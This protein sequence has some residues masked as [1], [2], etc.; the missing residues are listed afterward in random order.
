[1]RFTQSLIRFD[2]ILLLTAF[3]LV[4]VGLVVMYGI[5]ISRPES[6]LFLFQKQIAGA[7]IGLAVIIGLGF[8]DYR[9]LRGLALP[10]YAAGAALLVGVLLF[11]H[12]VRGTKGWYVV[13]GLSFQPVEMAKLCL[14]LF[15]ASYLARYTHQR[16]RWHAVAGSFLGTAG[17]AALVFLQPDFGSAMVMFAIWGIL[18]LCVGLT[19]KNVLVLSLVALVMAGMAWFLLL[20][21]YQHARF[22]AFVNPALDERG[23]GYNVTQAQIAIG[24][25]GLFGKG[26]GEGSQARLRFLPEA[27]TDFMFAVV[28]EELGFVGIVFVLGLFGL[29]FYRFLLVAREAED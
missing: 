23:A 12:T 24:S 7:V 28:G 26:V 18:I 1:M 2:W 8:V 16:L 13:G 19:W 6:S 9:Q 14:I 3:T 5:G 15:L 21:P 20:K 22:L 29:L 4:S 17:Y 10:V 11:G 27:A 25:G